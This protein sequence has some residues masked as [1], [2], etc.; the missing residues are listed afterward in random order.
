MCPIPRLL[1]RKPPTLSGWGAFSGLRLDAEIGG[2]RFYIGVFRPPL[3][4]WPPD[5]LEVP[6]VHPPAH[7]LR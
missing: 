3:P 6:G 2:E 7:R 4:G 5:V 1:K